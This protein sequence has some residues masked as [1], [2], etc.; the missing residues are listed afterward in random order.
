MLRKGQLQQRRE[1]NGLRKFNQREL[2]AHITELEAAL[3]AEDARC[4]K[5]KIGYASRFLSSGKRKEHEHKKTNERR[6]KM[7]ANK[8]ARTT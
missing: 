1:L 5:V 6:L 2:V 7:E 3:T 4:A 8:M